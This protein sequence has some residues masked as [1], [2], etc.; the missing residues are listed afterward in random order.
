MLRFRSVNCSC[1]NWLLK[2]VAISMVIVIAGCV[3]PR[4][5]PRYLTVAE[6]IDN[7]RCELY[8]AVVENRGTSSWLL[9]YSALLDVELEVFREGGLRA[10]ASYVVP[11]LGGLATINLIA[12]IKKSSKARVAFDFLA[13][14]N[15]GEYIG[16]KYVGGQWVINQ[17]V[18]PAYCGILPLHR[19]GRYI[20]GETGLRLWLGKLIEGI[21][22]T[23]IEIENAT[24]GFS[25]FVEFIVTGDGNIIPKIDRTRTNGHRFFGNINASRQRRDTHK[26]TIVFKKVFPPSTADTELKAL[27]RIEI[28][29]GGTPPERSAIPGQPGAPGRP[30]VP[31]LPPIRDSIKRSLNQELDRAFNRDSR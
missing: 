30:A 10:D 22:E 27:R 9:N 12:G 5:F 2:I 7:L 11:H 6:V 1:I 3:K 8:M 21:D 19:N 26:L 16:M 17:A 18:S 29:L 14:N 4:K 25:Y 28:L 15:L 31:A 20:A 13:G 24:D 23:G